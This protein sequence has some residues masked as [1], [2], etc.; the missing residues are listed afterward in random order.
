MTAEPLGQE[1]R[2][3]RSELEEDL[4]RVEGLRAVRKRAGVIRALQDDLADGLGRLE[5]GAVVCLVGSTGAGKSTLVNALAGATI[6]TP[7]VHR[8]TTTAPVVY[9]PTDLADER[10]AI[11]TDDP[12]LGEVRVVRYTPRPGAPWAGQVFIDAP[13]VNSVAEH[14]RERVRTLVGTADFLLVVLHR[15]SIAEA[16]P[17]SFLDQWADRRELLF[18]LGH[19]DQLT[20]EA[21]EALIAQIS[22]IATERWG[23][24]SPRVLALS[25][26]HAV[27]DP[28][29]PDFLALVA[30]LRRLAETEVVEG[31]RRTRLHGTLAALRRELAGA[32]DE[33]SADL[34]ALGG[35]VEAALAEVRLYVGEE[36]T[37]R[38]SARSVDLE[39]QLVDE[40]GKRWRGPGGW[41]LRAGSVTGVGA[42]LGALVARS[43]L[44]GGAVLAAGSALAD[45]GASQLRQWRIARGDELLPASADLEDR[46][47]LALVAAQARAQR[48]GLGADALEIEA[49]Q[50]SLSDGL[51]DAWTSFV[52][53]DLPEA[54][55][56]WGHAFGRFLLDAPLYALGAWMLYEVGEGYVESR[57]EGVPFLVDSL[58]IGAAYAFVERAVAGWLV[59]RRVRQVID[60]ARQSF[61][62]ALGRAAR[63]HMQRLAALLQGQREALDRLAQS[64]PR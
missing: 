40:V 36:V 28:T 25:A 55:A 30:A 21:R 37:R 49:L 34:E 59:A 16:S 64:P 61:D 44:A 24:T 6:A 14:H 1:L 54:A 20:A 33:A 19:A 12:S 56:G 46:L 5:D 41:L 60:D 43:S 53:R 18:V 32:R 17:V 7:G 35:D 13:D 8:P 9:A 27:E 15:Q 57:Y 52:G 39:R 4:A 10:L 26:S 58:V 29:D 31:V 42:G 2:R 48:L 23:I 3:L 45:R 22:G 11:W 63:R 38:L 62:H 50:A 47:E 51:T